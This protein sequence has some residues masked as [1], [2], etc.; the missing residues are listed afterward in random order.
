MSWAS[1]SLKN[2]T[3]ALR[4]VSDWQDL[5][6]QLD[7]QYHELQKF[8]SEHQ[9]TEERK[10]AMLQFWLDDD[11]N[12]SWKKVISAL[13]EMQLNRVAEEIK[14]K[15]Q[16]PPT[17]WSE[18]VPPPTVTAE[19]ESVPTADPP[20]IPL[21]DQPE[22]TLTA[23]SENVTAVDLALPTDQTEGSSTEG[24]TKVQL[25]MPHLRPCTM[26]W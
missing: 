3:N 7:I 8:V 22:A 15:Y 25:E 24:V 23:Q 20:S 21:N 18:D 10:R 9:T 5:G 13:S 16:L 12:A 4:E 17:T 11:T 19:L 14:R 26:T 2:L 6:I 1:L